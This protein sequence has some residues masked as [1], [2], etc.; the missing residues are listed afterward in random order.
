MNRCR[1]CAAK[2]RWVTTASGRKMPVDPDP[3]R[4]DGE[5]LFVWPDGE[6]GRTHPGFT[7]GYVSHFATCPKAGSFR[8]R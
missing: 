2:V 3:V 6:V 7:S 5:R 4:P 1:G 8:K